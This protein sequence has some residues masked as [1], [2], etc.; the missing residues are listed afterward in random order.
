MKKTILTLL[1][2]FSTLLASTANA[3]SI[4]IESEK[5]ADISLGEDT[6]I[7]VLIST[8]GETIN[9]FEG[10]IEFEEQSFSFF[11]FQMQKSITS[12]WIKQPEVDSGVIEFSGMIPG[13]FTGE[14]S[15]LFS[16][17]IIGKKPGKG[18]VT[19]SSSAIYLHDGDGTK[20]QTRNDNIKIKIGENREEGAQITAELDDYPPEPFKLVVTKDKEI[21]EGD[22]T[23]FFQ[24]QDKGSG[25]ALYQISYNNGKTFEPAV[26]PIN[27]S[28]KNYKDIIVKA[29]DR[30]GNEQS[31]RLDQGTPLTKEQ[32]VVLFSIALVLTWGFIKLNNKR[33]KLNK[34]K[35]QK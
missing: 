21:N 9:A 16:F 14:E 33:R 26:S 24:T 32:A 5:G 6:K 8:Q 35:I 30:R 20:I 23:L 4:H 29:I 7:S 17:V 18:D 10:K 1:L 28:G 11:D 31:V 25:I 22:P 34:K 13:G 2:I 3:A 27:I 15:E 19:L 12:L